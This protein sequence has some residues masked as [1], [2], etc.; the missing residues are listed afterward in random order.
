MYN[1]D[2]ATK[3]QTSD[4][5]GRK[6]NLNWTN[7][8]IQSIF[9]EISSSLTYKI[10]HCSRQ[11]QNKRRKTRQCS[12]ALQKRFLYISAIIFP[13]VWKNTFWALY[14]QVL[15]IL[16][17]ILSIWVTTNLR[18]KPSFEFDIV[19]IYYV[20]WTTYICVHQISESFQSIQSS[21]QTAEL[22]IR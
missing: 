17:V 1:I 3:Q 11:K 6:R 15:E 9:T 12:D 16:F 13:R 22:R 18:T 4:S 20:L 14:L 10:G 21:M 2:C 5:E 7:K 19:K 8:I